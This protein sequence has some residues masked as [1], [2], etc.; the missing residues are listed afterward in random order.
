MPNCFSRLFSI[1]ASKARADGLKIPL[2]NIFDVHIVGPLLKLHAEY[3]H[4]HFDHYLVPDILTICSLLIRTFGLVCFHLDSAPGFN[5]RHNR[6]VAA[7]CFL[8]G[9]YFDCLDGFY[10]RKYNKCTMFGCWL[11]HLNDIVTTLLFFV[12]AFVKKMWLTASLMCLMFIFVANQV[13][14]EE[15]SFDDHTEFF[16][17]AMQCLGY[18]RLFKGRDFMKFF[19]TSSWFLIVAFSIAFE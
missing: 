17:L 7:L 10:A 1:D 15:E 16:G 5:I 12:L 2:V 4:T 11:D 14:V 9:Y 8:A 6:I 13:L 19:G 18:F 3:I